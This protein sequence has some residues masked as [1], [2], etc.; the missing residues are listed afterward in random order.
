MLIIDARP[1]NPAGLR[2][3]SFGEDDEL[4]LTPED[5]RPRHTR[6]VRSIC[7][8][9]TKGIPGGADL[10]PQVIKPG[11]GAPMNAGERDAHCWAG[12]GRPA[13]AHITV[14]FDGAIY[15]HADLL[16]VAAYHAGSVNEVSIGIEIYQG[17]DAGLYQGQLDAVVRLVDWLTARFGIQRQIP[18]AYHGG[19][20]LRLE[21]GAE[22]FV[23]V[24]GH[25]DCSATRGQGD[26]GDAVFAALAAAGY[27]QFD[28]GAGA[29]IARWKVRQAQLGLPADG[30]PGPA[31]VA[32]LA[33]RGMPSGI[34]SRP[35]GDPNA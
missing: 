9:T 12:D 35:P 19:P 22:D 20:I 8:H 27:E 31:T 21:A 23:G 3:T 18:D 5:Y 1:E 32:A 15:Q 10:R 25:R 34:W 6:W 29:D 17:S 4:V 14:D 26:P 28:I 33:A 30:I 11:L 7:L 13:A 2:T 16:T 24:F